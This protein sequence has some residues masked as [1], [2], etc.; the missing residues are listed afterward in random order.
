VF[1]HKLFAI[2]TNSGKQCVG[3]VLFHYICA[4]THPTGTVLFFLK[5]EFGASPV[6]S[7]CGFIYGLLVLQKVHSFVPEAHTLFYKTSKIF[8]KLI[9]EMWIVRLG[10]F[11]E[12]QF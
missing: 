7:K 6:P 10:L 1:T 4:R 5:E 11:S 12:S 3:Y 9:M 8:T 2:Q